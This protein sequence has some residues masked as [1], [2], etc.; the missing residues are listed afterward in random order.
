[1]STVE[2]RTYTP[3]DLLTMPDG[4]RFELVDGEL[5]E[6]DMGGKSSWVGGQVFTE[7]SLHSRTHGGWAFPDSTSYQCFS[8]D[9]NRVRKP[10]ASY[11]GPGRFENDE[12]PEGHIRVPPDLAVEVVSPNDFYYDVEKK[13]DEYLRAGV[14][15]VWVVNPEFWT[16]RV[17][18]DSIQNLAQF[19]PDDELTGGDVLPEFRCRVSD[20]FANLQRS[21]S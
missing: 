9:P 20:L 5:V 12:I 3:E 8:V 21:S 15:M 11:V 16:V 6:I 2:T 10:D 19:G 18:R 17:F 1:M 14:R 13:V 4:D 7:L